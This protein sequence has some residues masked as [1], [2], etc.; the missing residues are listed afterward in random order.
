M[1]RIVCRRSGVEALRAV[2]AAAAGLGVLAAATV[3]P[4]FFGNS[5]VASEAEPQTVVQ[6][7]DDSL[8][9]VKEKLAA[10]EAVLLDVRDQ[11]EWDEGRLGDAKHLPLKQILKGVPEEKLGKIAPK[12]KVIYLHCVVGARSLEAARTLQPTGRDLRPL[13]AGY[14]DLLKAGFPKADRPEGPD[15]NE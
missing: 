15:E 1:S 8:D 13:K 3:G 7:T 11:D 10:G 14:K 9:T 4:A 5:L 6:L 2:F 12:G